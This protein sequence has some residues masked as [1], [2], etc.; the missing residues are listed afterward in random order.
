MA[1]KKS[2]KHQKKNPIEKKRNESKIMQSKKRLN[3]LYLFL[4]INSNIF[5]LFF[6][7]EK[8]YFFLKVILNFNPILNIFFP[9]LLSSF[10]IPIKNKRSRRENYSIKERKETKNYITVIKY[11]ILLNIFIFAF[12]N[13]HL[14]NLSTITLKI[15]G[16]GTKKIFGTHKIWYFDTKNYP[17]R[18][19]INGNES[20]VNHTYYLNQD[21][22]T[23]ELIW[24]NEI[25][26]C[27]WMFYECSDI[28]EIDLSNFNTSKV[29]NIWGMFE[30]CSKLTYRFV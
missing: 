4:F 20:I 17:N 15:E 22:N 8:L 11:I 12:S 18:V 28:T 19:I 3:C 25:D 24:Y 7:N 13:N 14:Y 10:L 16:T 23:I 27:S 6:Y 29:T 5:L 26:N 2:L 1:K 21:N 9:S 30:S